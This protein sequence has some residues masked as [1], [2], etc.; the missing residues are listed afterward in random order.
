VNVVGIS[1]P[2][3]MVKTVCD[4]ADPPTAVTTPQ[5]SIPCAGLHGRGG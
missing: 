1:L 2:N 4:G 3:S 5:R